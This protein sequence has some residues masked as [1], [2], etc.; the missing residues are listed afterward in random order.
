MHHLVAEWH[1]GLSREAQ[2]GDRTYDHTLAENGSRVPNRRCAQIGNKENRYGELDPKLAEQ[3][4]KTGELFQ[5]RPHSLNQQWRLLS[6]LSVLK[7][8]STSRVLSLKG[9]TMPTHCRT[10]SYNRLRG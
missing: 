8:N 7:A 10:T 1:D 2:S 3:V 6:A 5:L 4:S 9:S